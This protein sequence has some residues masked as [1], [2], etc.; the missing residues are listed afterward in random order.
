MSVKKQADLRRSHLF[1]ASGLLGDYSLS[2]SCLNLTDIDSLD[3][4]CNRCMRGRVFHGKYCYYC[5]RRI[6][7]EYGVDM[8][9]TKCYP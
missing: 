4:L 7:Y 8:D 1:G 3:S 9:D 6:L 5:C 2:S